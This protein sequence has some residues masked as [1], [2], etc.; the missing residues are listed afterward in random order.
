MVNEAEVDIFW[1]SPVFSVIQWMLKIWSLVPLPFLNATCTLHLKVISSCIVES[2]LKDFEQNL[3]SMWNENNCMVVWPFFGIDLF[4]D[5]KE[6]WSFLVLWPLLSFLTLSLPQHQGLFQWVGVCIRWPKNWSFSF[7][8]NLCNEYSG[9]IQYQICWYWVQDF[10]S[11]GVAKFCPHGFYHF[12]S[13][14][15]ELQS[16]CFST[17]F[18]NFCDF[19]PNGLALESTLLI[20]RLSQPQRIMTRCLLFFSVLRIQKRI[21]WINPSSQ[22]LTS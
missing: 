14:P 22:E 17:H 21:R 20:T 5:W 7:S 2:S 16:D 13:L 3:A 15:A 10:D 11:L 18:L 9:N 19:E 1:N 12:V 6:I 8:I 4:W